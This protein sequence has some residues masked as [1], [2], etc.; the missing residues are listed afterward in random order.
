MSIPALTVLPLVLAA[1][2]VFSGLLKRAD[3]ERTAESFAAFSLPPM[4]RSRWLVQAFPWCEVAL[5]AGLLA[6]SDWSFVVATALAAALFTA[7]AA[8]VAWAVLGRREVDCNCFGALSTEPVGRWTVLRNIVLAAAAGAQF[9]AAMAGGLSGLPAAISGFTGTDWEWFAAVLALMVTASGALAVLAA[10]ATRAASAAAAGSE[11]T[12][13]D[14]SGEEIP[15][16]ELSDDGGTRHRLRDL[17]TGGSQLLVFVSP[18]C[19]LCPP[20]V[21][22]LAEWSTRFGSAVRIRPVTSATPAE[23]QTAYP[24]AAEDALYDRSTMASSLL[25]VIGVPA[26]VLLGTNGTIGAGPAHGTDDVLDLMEGIAAAV[27]LVDRS[28]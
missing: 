10:K 26:A 12:G 14:R 13:S 1:V 7:Y 6:L 3:P 2:L 8:L 27:E 18:G 9:W 11:Q 20:M 25:G 24:A 23:L 17:A 28:S 5:G 21:D 15:L 22:A 16:A 4:L 19:A